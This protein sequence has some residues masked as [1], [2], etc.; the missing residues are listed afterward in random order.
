MSRETRALD[1]MPLTRPAFEPYGQ[2]IDLDDLE[3]SAPAATTV[4]LGT[5]RKFA[6]L[7]LLELSGGDGAISVFRSQPRALPM[8]LELLERHPLGSQAFLPVEATRF[9]I[10]VAGSSMEPSR[11]D[12]RLFIAQG[13]KGVNFRKGVWHHPLLALDRACDFLVVDRQDQSRNLEEWD[14]RD[15]RICLRS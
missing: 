8:E 6:D 3:S 13:R 11:R 5:S 14:I 15:W 12:L 9:A 7:A 1:P 2:V 10:V 4:N